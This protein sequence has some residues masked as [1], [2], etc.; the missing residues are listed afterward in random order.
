MGN[1]TS[2]IFVWNDNCVLWCLLNR[3]FSSQWPQ[4]SSKLRFASAWVPH[5]YSVP[6]LG[7][8]LGGS[9]A[10]VSLYF[11]DEEPQSLNKWELV[12]QGHRLHLTD[13]RLSA[14][15]I[16]LPLG[17]WLDGSG[18]EQCPGLPSFTLLASRVFCCGCQGL[19]YSCLLTARHNQ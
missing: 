14:I 10:S 7:L 2:E 6:S 1:V 15:F 19:W 3:L 5:L 16:F 9:S 13:S 8:L 4:P 17:I 18:P 12:L 11:T